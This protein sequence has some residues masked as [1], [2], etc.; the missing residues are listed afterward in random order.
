[1]NLSYS[2]CFSEIT[3][4]SAEFGDFSDSGVYE[5]GVASLRDIIYTATRLGIRGNSKNDSTGWWSSGFDTQDYSTGTEREYTL[6]IEGLSPKN[7]AHV[8]ALL[9]R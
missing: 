8:N 5:N 7:F 6:H 1:M 3:P 2:I 4:E 9:N